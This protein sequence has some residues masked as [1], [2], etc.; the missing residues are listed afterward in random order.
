[1]AD[2]VTRVTRGSA[3][4]RSIGKR[5][6]Y[7]QV[8]LEQRQAYDLAAEVMAAAALTED[9]QEGIAAFLGKRPAAYT[10]LP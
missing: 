7:A 5:T 3:M 1:V 2:L 6:F 9:A 4:G 8:G 10:S